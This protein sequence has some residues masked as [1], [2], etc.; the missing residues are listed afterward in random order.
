MP[1]GNLQDKKLLNSGAETTEQLLAIAALVCSGVPTKKEKKKT[2]HSR[3]W[4]W[5]WL[6]EWGQQVP[7]KKGTGSEL[8]QLAQEFLVFSRCIP[9]YNMAQC[10]RLLAKVVI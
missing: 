1:G 3:M 8:R 7:H 5:P 9:P 4:T 2:R 10:H 6:R